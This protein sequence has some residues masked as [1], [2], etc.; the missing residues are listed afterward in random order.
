M[1]KRCQVCDGPIVN[2]RCKYCG[3]PYRNDMEL[4]HLNEER[5]DHY[6]HAS[7]K[8]RK[9]MAESEIPL[10]DRNETVPKSAKA[11]SA[12]TQKTVSGTQ[13][14]RL[15]TAR[16]H[17]EK[18]QT[19]GVRTSGAKK[20][21]GQ[22]YSPQTAR[23]Y[24]T[25]RKTKRSEKKRSSRAGKIFWI[26]VLILMVVIGQM[27]EHW[28]TIGYRIEKFIYDE[29]DIDLSSIFDN[30][31]ADE[32]NESDENDWTDDWSETV[33]AVKNG[34]DEQKDNPDWYMFTGENYIVRM[35]DT[36]AEIG[37][38]DTDS[39]KYDFTIDP[40]EYRIESGWEKVALEIKSSSGKDE[41]VTFD[42]AGH[43]EKIKLHAGDEVSVV[44]LDGQDNYLSMY[45]IQQYDE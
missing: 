15:Q 39:Q 23:T 13:T 6:R 25:G 32:V 43:E 10:P 22:P 30:S 37:D 5:S 1:G 35:D 24:S 14:V 27:A 11:S 19:S 9:A 20:T 3:M 16:T 36:A 40:G 44:S 21:V 29:F 26:T 2:G 38:T 12:R 8:V 45:Q 31:S 18:A 41:T 4:Y 33:S 28:D 17:N 34:Q 7:A 42:E